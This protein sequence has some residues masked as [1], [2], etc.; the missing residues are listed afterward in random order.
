MYTS[1]EFEN[2]DIFPKKYTIGGVIKYS[3]YIS[4]M[5]ISNIFMYSFYSGRDFLSV[6]SL[7]K[8]SNFLINRIANKETAKLYQNYTKYTVTYSDNISSYFVI[9]YINENHPCIIQNGTLG[10]NITNLYI[11]L[12]NTLYTDNTLKP[13]FVEKKDNPYTEYFHKN[14]LYI[15]MNYTDFLSPNNDTYT[16]VIND[17]NINILN[18]S[19]SSILISKYIHSPI[20]RNYLNDLGIYYTEGSDMTQIGG[21]QEPSENFICVLK[22]EINIMLIP[23]MQRKYVYPFLPKYGPVYYSQVNF[24]NPNYKKY[25]LFAKVNKVN[26]IIT[27]GDCL[28]V[29]SYWYRSILTKRK[30][31]FK[32]ITLKYEPPSRYLNEI[33]KG[34]DLG[35]F[36]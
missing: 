29:P 18:S 9:D 7:Q 30:E 6:I 11:S 27:K 19:L 34:I 14:F 17:H 15:R 10:F 13:L 4:F 32:Y 33:I 16:Y 12:N 31:E 26:M 5:I 2:F 36:K 22:G 8:S 35:R 24:F 23:S 1:E 21:H 25:P 28:Y 20:L 3:L